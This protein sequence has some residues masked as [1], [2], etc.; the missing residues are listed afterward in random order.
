MLDLSPDLFGADDPRQSDAA[1]NRSQGEVNVIFNFMGTLFPT[2]AAAQVGWHWPGAQYL[3][4]Y[5]GLPALGIVMTEFFNDS[6]AGYYG[7]T[8]HWNYVA[9]FGDAPDLP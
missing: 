8:V 4:Q 5:R 2:G 3:G 7:N 9:A 6:I 1:P